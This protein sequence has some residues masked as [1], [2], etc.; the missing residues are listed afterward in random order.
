MYSKPNNIDNHN[1][2]IDTL[3][4]NYREIII[5]GEVTI[6]GDFNS[7]ATHLT[8]AQKKRGKSQYDRTLGRLLKTTPLKPLMS[9]G[10]EVDKDK[11]WTYHGYNGTRSVNDYIL[12]NPERSGL[13]TR[14][15]VHQ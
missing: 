7:H 8:P 1:K 15:K 10:K 5:L 13:N 4:L 11:H 3:M 2:V 6:M 12:T 14:Y 9:K